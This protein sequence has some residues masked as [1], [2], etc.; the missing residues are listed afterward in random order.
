MDKPE[1]THR[2]VSVHES[3]GMLGKNFTGACCILAG[4]LTENLHIPG[5][6]RV[7][8][9]LADGSNDYGGEY[10]FSAVQICLLGK[11][12]KGTLEEVIR[13]EEDLEEPMEGSDDLATDDVAPAD[14]GG[15]DAEVHT[16][17]E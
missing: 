13:E 7:R 1:W 2:I 6:D 4:P 8:L 17:K 15:G 9:R 5:Y 12:P 11:E 14:N 16:P 3:D 10:N